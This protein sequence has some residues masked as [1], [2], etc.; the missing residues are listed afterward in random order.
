MK[1]RVAVVAGLVLLAWLFPQAPAS[2]RSNWPREWRWWED[3][4]VEAEVTVPQRPVPPKILTF[5]ALRESDEGRQWF[6]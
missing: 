2:W 6:G 3:L 1:R 5:E 4:L